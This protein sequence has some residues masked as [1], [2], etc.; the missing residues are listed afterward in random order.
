M[1]T[2]RFARR[3]LDEILPQWLDAAFD[4]EAG[5][6]MEGLEIVGGAQISGIVRTRTI[7]RQ[8]FTFA[9]TAHLGLAPKGALEAAETAFAHLDAVAWN[10]SGRPGYARAFDR[11]TR[12]VTDPLVDLYDLAC[13]EL[14]LAWLAKA[15]GRALYRTRA[16]ELFAVIE[17]RLAAP[18]GGFAEDDTGT[19]PRRQNPHM[20]LFEAAMA[21]WETGGSAFEPRARALFALFR[22]RLLDE[23]GVLREFFGP[24]WQLDDA[25]GS[26]RL[27]PG[28]MAEWVWLVHRYERLAGES[29]GDIASRLLT[30]A[31]AMGRPAGS[32]FI[33]DEVTT[34]GAIK[35]SRRLWLQVEL[36]KAFMSE[37]RTA[38]AEA[39]AAAITD[40]YLA[41]SAEGPWR[42]CFDLEGRPTATSVPGS[43]I[44]HLWTAVADIVA[45]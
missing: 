13:V 44:Y 9:H 26:N 29:H 30:T 25:L 8:I 14:A 33:V 19:L 10:A 34:A 17:T 37:G 35:P 20:H 24:N 5:Q 12:L 2:A 18:G 1:S 42:D 22:D 40:G 3:Y 41:P 36:L 7:A 38:E 11:R 32:P 6:F 16:E 31:L 27:E 4:R 45:G 15:T 23:A 39:M 21:H 43:S 28:H